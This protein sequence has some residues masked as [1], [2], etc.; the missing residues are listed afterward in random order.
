MKMRKYYSGITAL[1]FLLPAFLL[2]FGK[3]ISA[4]LVFNGGAIINLNGGSSSAQ[5]AYLRL[6]NPPA[7]PITMN[8]GG[9]NGIMMETEYSITRYNLKNGITAITI[10]YVSL[11][12]ESF[13]L[14]FT[15]TMAGTGGSS[16]GNIE[17]SST[18]S[19]VRSTG[20]DN[21]NYMPSDVNNMSSMAMPDN[22]A[23]VLDRFWI[24][25]AHNYASSPAVDL[26]FAYASA[27]AAGNGGNFILQPNLQAQAY[28]MDQNSWGVYP[29]SGVNSSLGSTGRIDGVS[30][31]SGLM[32]GD[33]YRS[34]TLADN[35][36]PLSIDMMSVSGNCDQG[37]VTLTWITRTETN[38]ATFLIEKSEDALLFDVVAKMDAAGNTSSGKSY[39]YTDPGTSSG[40]GYYRITEIDKNGS[41]S[42]QKILEVTCLSKPAEPVLNLYA[43]HGGI[44]VS[45]NSPDD[46]SYVIT[47]FDLNGREI[48]R[49]V[50]PASAGENNVV[51]SFPYAPGIYLFR[52][53]SST[54]QYSR[55]AFVQE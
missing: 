28:N 9:V 30:L 44:Y 15:P 6:N 35:S 14:V 21:I 55:K 53:E 17:F 41:V 43:A 39:S 31:G 12:G 34:W 16:N 5:S 27:E 47:A 24:I 26:S 7:V 50:V 49:Y 22:S 4:Q 8:G 13:P 37:S 18:R 48:K 40:T 23:S 20:W 52:I 32:G 10:P 2:L 19:S 36:T 38:S 54:H 46:E 33:G 29:L 42:Y 11:Y 45:I 1:H 25:D 51:L 3:G